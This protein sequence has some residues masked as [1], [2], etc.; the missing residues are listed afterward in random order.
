MVVA[1]S[2]ATAAGGAAIAA[3]ARCQG[4]VVLE[5]NKGHTTFVP[6]VLELRPD[7]GPGK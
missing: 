4:L 7:I 2:S 6:T 1:S 3:G 5:G